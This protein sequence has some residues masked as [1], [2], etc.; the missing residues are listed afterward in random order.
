LGHRKGVPK[1]GSASSQE[2]RS[3]GLEFMMRGSFDR[4]AYADLG[5]GAT[6]TAK[7]LLPIEA[8]NPHLR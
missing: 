2:R 1:L 6:C 7:K 4:D 5:H 3:S 8:E